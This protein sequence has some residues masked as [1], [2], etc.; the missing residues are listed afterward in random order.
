MCVLVTKCIVNLLTKSQY[1][2]VADNNLTGIVNTRF[3]RT[4][5]KRFQNAAVI[6][7]RQVNLIKLIKI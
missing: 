3:W 5:I 7:V 1:L 6:Y 4:C 2:N